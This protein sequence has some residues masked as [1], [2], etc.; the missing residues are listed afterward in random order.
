MRSSLCRD[1][2]LCGRMNDLKVWS[3]V[4]G[5]TNYSRDPRISAVGLTR[6]D[7]DD[8]RALS[9][10]RVGQ[11]EEKHDKRKKPFG[12]EVLVVDPVPVLTIRHSGKGIVGFLR[13]AENPDR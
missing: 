6:R 5:E 12:G 4:S 13:G 9:V 7:R 2:P 11:R 8:R 3:D 10:A 1:N